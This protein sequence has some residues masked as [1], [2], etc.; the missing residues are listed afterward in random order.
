MSQGNRTRGASSMYLTAA[1]NR[2][3]SIRKANA[4]GIARMNNTS[5]SHWL[6]LLNLITNVC[7]SPIPFKLVPVSFG[8]SYVCDTRSFITCAFVSRYTT[9]C[10]FRRIARNSSLLIRLL[11]RQSGSDRILCIRS[12]SAIPASASRFSLQG[13]SAA[14]ICFMAAMEKDRNSTETRLQTTGLCPIS[15]AI[16]TQVL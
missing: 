3:N 6:F 14:V 11:Y 5:H 4:K 16:R 13:R 15:S 1:G 10:S 7:F 12:S 2:R 8:T 9:P